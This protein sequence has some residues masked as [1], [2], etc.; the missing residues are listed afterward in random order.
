MK[1]NLVP[2]NIRFYKKSQETIKKIILDNLPKNVEVYLFGSGVTSNHS[3]NSD[4]DVAI[5]PH[6]DFDENIIRK[7]K[8]LIED[9]YVPFKVDIIDLRKVSDEF[10]KEVFKKVK[11]WR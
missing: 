1:K 6:S 4:I 10:I 9:S 11:K 2:T 7:I 5:N 8:D 3:Y